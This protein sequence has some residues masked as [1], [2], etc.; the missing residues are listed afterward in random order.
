MSLKQMENMD[1]N[2]SIFCHLVFVINKAKNSQEL[3]L[4]EQI[5]LLVLTIPTID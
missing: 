1:R 5:C 2:L 4:L 3:G